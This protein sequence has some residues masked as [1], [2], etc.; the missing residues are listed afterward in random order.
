MTEAQDLLLCL[1]DLWNI[2]QVP[3]YLLKLRT[4]KD[5]LQMTHDIRSRNK[6]GDKY[7][8]SYNE[9][10]WASWDQY[11]QAH[12]WAEGILSGQDTR[13]ADNQRE[14][15][16]LETAALFSKIPGYFSTQKPTSDLML[17]HVTLQPGDHV[18][19]PSAGSG[20]LADAIMER[21]PEVDLRVVEQ[22]YTLRDILSLKGYDLIGQDIMNLTHDQLDFLGI[23]FDAVIMNP[24]FEK[25]QDADH[26][27]HCYDLLKDNGILVSVM[28]TSPFNNHTNRKGSD[29]REWF[30]SVGGDKYDL[31]DGS[32][33][34]SGTGVASCY[35][36]IRR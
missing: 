13:E 16:R 24:P 29:F 25:L 17:E 2:G 36:V 10:T 18:L 32:F 23:R 8:S 4:K 1:A 22:S 7:P 28:S 12:A 31:P 5:V 3:A 9:R 35:V 21:F 19:E 20:A 11:N 6:Y 14:I 27:R 26:V 30:D 15:Q 34:K 33:K